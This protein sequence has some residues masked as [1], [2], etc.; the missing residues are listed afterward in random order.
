M[1]RKGNQ[2]T[3]G[4]ALAGSAKRRAV[5][6]GVQ[7]QR[8]SLEQVAISRLRRIGSETLAEEGDYFRGLQ[9]A[10]TSAVDFGLQHIE[11]AR[12]PVPEPILAQVRLA[13]RRE[14]AVGI[15]LRR[16][17]SAYSLFLNYLMEEADRC[18]LTQSEARA[19]RDTQASAF[20]ALMAEV[21]VEYEL[22]SGPQVQSLESRVLHRLKRV[23]DGDVV[24]LGDL[25][26]PFGSYNLAIVARGVGVE[27]RLRRTARRVDRAVLTTRVGG[28][29]LWG[30]LGGQ[31]AFS[32][33]EHRVISA[34]IQAEGS[35][36]ALGEPCVGLEGWR[37][38]H[39]QARAALRVADGSSESFVR[40]ADVA[41]IASAQQDHLF[42]LSLREIYLTPLAG[43]RDGGAKLLATLRAYIDAGRN[44]SSAAAALGVSRRTVTKR[45]QE[46]EDRLGRPI[47]AAIP[48][49]DT[50][51]RLHAPAGID[52]KPA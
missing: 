27:Q 48:A 2:I 44:V 47:S 36:V 30:W 17:V 12:A 7:R 28:E 38:S 10:L 37:L 11:L 50:A 22:E 41:V 9:L 8:A 45:I 1:E 35:T 40:Y 23:L 49:L 34:L 31:R 3:S 32:I 21:M 25:G 15:V 20:D 42:A 13:A 24:G 29:V 14:V 51:L 18:S 26:Y 19:L 46:V 39:R 52:C 6:V 4:T 5:A 16:C 43:G 33:E